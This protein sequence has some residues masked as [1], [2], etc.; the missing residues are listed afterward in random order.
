MGWL[1]GKRGKSGTIQRLGKHNFY[2]VKFR[3]KNSKYYSCKFFKT[4][5]T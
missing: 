4:S 3:R 2:T 1:I 5:K